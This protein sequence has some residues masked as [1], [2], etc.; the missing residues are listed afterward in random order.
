MELILLCWLKHVACVVSFISVMHLQVSLDEAQM[1][2][3]TNVRAAEMTKK[4]SAVNRWCVTGTPV[5]RQLLGWY[6][7]ST[8]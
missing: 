2:E 6:D 3:S 8:T 7:C 5:Q 4:L 1:V